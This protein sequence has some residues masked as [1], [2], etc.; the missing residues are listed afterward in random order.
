MKVGDLVHILADK[1]VCS[2]PDEFGI[3]GSRVMCR[4]AHGK[5]CLILE[6]SKYSEHQVLCHCV[7]AEGIVGWIQDGWIEVLQ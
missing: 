5:I 2:S 1:N 3:N 6:Q 4:I 7:L